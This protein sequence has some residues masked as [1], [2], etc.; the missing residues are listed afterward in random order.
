MEADSGIQIEL[1]RVDGGM[2]VNELLMQFQADILNRPVVRAQSVE[3]T[4]LGAACAAGL[5]TGW[6]Q[7]PAEFG[8]LTIDRRWDPCME[9]SRRQ[10]IY[11]RWKKAVSRSL[12]WLD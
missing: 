1:L 5:A 2:T 12:D 11:S 3:A 6:I 9:N 7:E 4:A 8:A 10:E